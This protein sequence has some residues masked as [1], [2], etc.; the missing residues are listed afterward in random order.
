MQIVKVQDVN[1]YWAFL[2][3]ELLAQNGEK[4]HA[5][6]PT[7]Y[8]VPWITYNDKFTD[9][10]LQDSQHSFKSVVCK[11]LKNNGVSANECEATVE[12]WGSRRA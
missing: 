6:R 8:F 12:K 7:L 11:E 5:L 4:T 9:S 3:S 2:G 1:N 10:N